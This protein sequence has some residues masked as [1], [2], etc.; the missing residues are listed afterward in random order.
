MAHNWTEEL[1]AIVYSGKVLGWLRSQARKVCGKHASVIDLE[2]FEAEVLRAFLKR[3]ENGELLQEARTNKEAQVFHVLGYAKLDVVRKSYTREAKEARKA[4]EDEA[5][6]ALGTTSRGAED[7]LEDAD[8]LQAAI[9]NIHRLASAAHK[10]AVL[11]SFLPAQLKADDVRAL[12]DGPS[13]QSLLVRAWAAAWDMLEAARA[14]LEVED[15]PHGMQPLAEAVSF[16]VSPGEIDPAS[17][18]K[19]IN[20]WQQHKSRALKALKELQEG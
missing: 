17:L 5:L 13:G 6:N 8:E 3:V 9:S 15:V 10:V 18:Q 12:G 20:R 19:A 16:D 1:R 4:W 7:L 11:W 2:A 14:L